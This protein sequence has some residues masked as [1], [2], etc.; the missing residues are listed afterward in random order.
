MKKTISSTIFFVLNIVF[1]LIVPIIFI[2][3]QYGDIQ[4][5]YKISV[6]AIL[7]ILAVFL[8]FKKLIINKWIETLN[9]RV[10]TI[11]SNS[12]SITD[13]KSIK[14]NKNVWRLCK[15]ISLLIDCIVP[16]GIAVISVLTIKVVEEGLIKLYGCL[17]FCLISI[18]LGVVCKIL[19]IFTTKLKHEA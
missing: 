11:E 2:W 7:I 16:I 5:T 3:L 15:T 8:F 19:E 6:T 1:M 12:L 4:G 14:A 10:V 9:L 17:M 18:A 13:E